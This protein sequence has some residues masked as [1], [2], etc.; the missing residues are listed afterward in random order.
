MMN[1]ELLMWATR[2]GSE[3]RFRE[4]ALSHATRRS[5]TISAPTAGSFHLVDYDP[6]TG[7][8]VQKQTVQG[9][10]DV[11]PWPRRPRAFFFFW[12]PFLTG[13]RGG[14]FSP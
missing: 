6:A 13:G 11:R 9:A 10:A 4:I 14:L 1:L 3:P 2:A 12:G 8:A 5:P 7:A